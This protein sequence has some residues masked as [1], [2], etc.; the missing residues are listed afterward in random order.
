MT[1]LSGDIR[2]TRI[3]AW[4]SLLRGRQTRV[5]LSTAAIFS[6][7]AGYFFENFRVEMMPAL[8]Y[9]D[10]QSVVSF[11]VIPKCMTWTVQ[12]LRSQNIATNY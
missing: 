11:S 9:S 3:F 1:L 6:V 10:T 2:L 7:F 4:G 5:R 8:L 12:V